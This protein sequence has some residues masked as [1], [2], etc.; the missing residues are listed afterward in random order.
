MSLARVPTERDL[1]LLDVAAGLPSARHWAAKVEANAE[2]IARLRETIDPRDFYASRAKAFQ[3]GGY[4]AT[5]WPRLLEL[6][7]PRDTWIDVGAGAGRLAVPLAGAVR[8]VVAVEPSAAMR[9]AL[10]SSLLDRGR[11]NVRIVDG[12]W[13]EVAHALAPA[14]VTLAAFVLFD[15]PAVGA[16]IGAMERR[17]TRRVVVSLTDRAPSA[18]DDEVWWELHGEAQAALPALSDFVQVLAELGRPV[19]ATTFPYE[20]PRAIAFDEAI[21]A[22]RRTYWV[23]PGSDK[24]L[25]LE[26]IL[27][28]RFMG[29]TGRVR[30]PATMTQVAVI[31][32]AP[33]R[34][35]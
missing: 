2:Q 32:W 26:D 29:R 12:R 23:R 15:Q 6:L 31:D 1:P 16:F 7:R 5:E 9:G 14:D 11:S 34:P 21:A 30:L 35:R 3:T 13:P 20:R 33:P 19:T 25:A 24:D 27:R 8:S 17:A 28:G 18:G 4:P 10:G 22:A